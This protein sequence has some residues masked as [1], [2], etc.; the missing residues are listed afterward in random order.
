MAKYTTSIRAPLRLSL[1]LLVCIATTTQGQ[2]IDGM[3]N[4]KISLPG[5]LCVYRKKTKA[6]CCL[7]KP[8]SCHIELYYCNLDCKRYADVAAMTTPPSAILPPLP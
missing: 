6:F 3:N 4:R 8:D 1:L 7:A 5:G 2:I